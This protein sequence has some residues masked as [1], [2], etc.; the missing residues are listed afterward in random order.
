MIGDD[1][2]VA[3]PPHRL[4]AH[5]RG[6]LA[7]RE[8]EQLGEAVAKLGGERV[9]RV[10][11]ERRDSPRV[12]RERGRLLGLAA[13]AAERG[14]RGVRDVALR[15]RLADRGLVELRIRARA[16]DRADVDEP[17]YPVRV[18][19]LGE[20]GDAAGGVSDREDR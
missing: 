10:V 15:E 9:V 3:A 7:A 4:G 14:E 2:A 1:P 11:L 18:E 6:R 8:R 20:L 5:D 19:Q 17:G 16:A 12:V 13:A